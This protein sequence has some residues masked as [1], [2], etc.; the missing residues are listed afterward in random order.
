MST[1]VTAGT[2]RNTYS[3]V[4]DRLRKRS[5]RAMCKSRKVAH[6]L[7][8]NAWWADASWSKGDHESYIAGVRDAL[9]AV[10]S[11]REDA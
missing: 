9:N 10:F 3:K 5:L 8:T 4:Y 11:D 7:G 1:K 6:V 2:D